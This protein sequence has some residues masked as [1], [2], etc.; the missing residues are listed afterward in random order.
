MKS[1]GPIPFVCVIRVFI[2]EVIV[3]LFIL[4]SHTLEWL[5]HISCPVIL[6]VLIPTELVSSVIILLHY[7]RFICIINANRVKLARI[8]GEDRVDQTITFKLLKIL[9]SS[10]FIYIAIVVIFTLGFIYHLIIMIVLNFNCSHYES[11]PFVIFHGYKI[12][13]IFIFLTAVLFILMDVYLNSGIFKLLKRGKNEKRNLLSYFSFKYDPYYFRIEIGFVFFLR[14]LQLVI[15][16][17]NFFSLNFTPKISIIINTIIILVNDSATTMF[18][19][20]L[21]IFK[22]Q[23]SKKEKKKEILEPMMNDG[24]SI[25]SIMKDKKMKK[26]FSQFAMKEWS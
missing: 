14:C 10:K 21:T 5:T 16:I 15:I 12:F 24:I 6:L 11:L 3:P 13:Y 2:S 7:V 8:L 17:F 20:L 1:R 4:E 9:S 19:L 22:S 18:P 26:A 23:K 25:E